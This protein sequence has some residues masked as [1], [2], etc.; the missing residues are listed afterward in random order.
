MFLLRLLHLYP[1]AVLIHLWLCFQHLDWL[2]DL[3]FLNFVLCCSPALDHFCACPFALLVPNFNTLCVYLLALLSSSWPFLCLSFCIILE[4]LTIFVQRSFCIAPQQL[5][6]IL[7]LFNHN[8]YPSLVF[9]S[10]HFTTIVVALFLLL[11]LILLFPNLCCSFFL[12][13]ILVIS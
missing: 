7:L 5:S 8:C 3:K 4:L 9:F 1:L 6:F 10:C 11:I 12:L 13:S 2:V